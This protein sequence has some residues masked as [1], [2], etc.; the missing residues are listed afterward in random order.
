ML[1]PLAVLLQVWQVV[2]LL[3]QLQLLLPCPR[4]T[5]GH[6]PGDASLLLLPQL[7][8]QQH[9]WCGASLALAGHLQGNCSK[10]VDKA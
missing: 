8:L 9:V 10:G 3:V 4:L 6:C 2:H 1:G 5:V 7:R